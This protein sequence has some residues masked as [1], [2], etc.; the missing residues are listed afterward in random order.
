MH[1]HRIHNALIG[2]QRPKDRKLPSGLPGSAPDMP[3]K[4]L[5]FPDVHL[6]T[7]PRTIANF[8]NRTCGT[9]ATVQF[10]ALDRHPR[11]PLDPTDGNSPR[12]SL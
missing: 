8:V 10:Y 11:A 9:L 4:H 3:I 12:P 1:L 6:A 7:G 2:E 5:G